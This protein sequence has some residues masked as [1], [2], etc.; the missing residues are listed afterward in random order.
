MI[1]VLLGGKLQNVQFHACHIS[2]TC[3][4][5]AMYS[6]FSFKSHTNINI[7]QLSLL[8]TVAVTSSLVLLSLIVS[9]PLSS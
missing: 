7:C 3:S 2:V 9:N 8:R 5:A 1:I 4:L 6:T